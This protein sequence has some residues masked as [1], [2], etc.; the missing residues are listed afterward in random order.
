LWD[1]NGRVAGTGLVLPVRWALGPGQMAEVAAQV[2]V[3]QEG[4]LSLRRDVELNRAVVVQAVDGATPVGRV[5][6]GVVDVRVAKPVLWNV[7][8]VLGESQETV[9]D[10]SVLGGTGAWS[11]PA[12][13]PELPADVSLSGGRLRVGAA[14]A[15]Q[16]GLRKVYLEQVSGSGDSRVLSVNL[17]T[18]HFRTSVFGEP[19]AV[20]DLA[21]RIP[22][23]ITWKAPIVWGAVPGTLDPNLAAL[24]RVEGGG[25]RVPLDAQL[26]F[27]G[28][29]TSL[30]PVR[31]VDAERPA[32]EV[33]GAVSVSVVQPQVAVRVV[34]EAGDLFPAVTDLKTWKPQLAAESGVRWR[35]LAEQG[36]LGLGGIQLGENGVL[37]VQQP[38]GT[39]A[40]QRTL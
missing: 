36:S 2:S 28:V 15:R 38:A 22:A 1:L 34:A 37:S 5:V 17:S 25:L 29:F 32:S 35:W 33:W 18:V 26:P 6:Y 4:T 3:G 14:D 21:E 9:V 30:V 10:L 31:G 7:A 40:R 39:P 12:W 13:Q 19:G 11:L 8:S 24:H 20:W 16:L 23:G 27:A